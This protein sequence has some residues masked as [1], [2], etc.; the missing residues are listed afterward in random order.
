M[1]AGKIAGANPF[2]SN[3]THGV[4][5]SS[6]PKDLETALQLLYL[7]FTDPRFDENEFQ[8]GIQQIMAVLPNLSKDPDFIFK[9]KIDQVFYNNNPRVTELTEETVKK[10]NLATIERVYRQLFKD[11]AGAEVIIVGNVDLETLKPLVEKYIG[12]LPKGKKATTWTVDNCISVATG[13]IEETVKLPMQT[14]KSTVRQLYTAYL[15]VDIKTNVTL[16]AANYILDMIYTKTIREDQGG[17]YG[18]GSALQG[19]REPS[20]RIDVHVLFS[21]NPEAAE[22][23]TQ[24]A[25][26]ELKKYAENGP[27][28]EQFNKA[29]ENLKKNL[30]EKR[31]NNGYWMNALSH[32]AEYGEDYDA[33]YEAAI[34]SLTAKDIQTVLQAILAQ[35]NFIEV[36]LTPAE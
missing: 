33:L 2:I 17:T 32:Y 4:S 7:T 8:T 10:A 1:L 12:S 16:D 15:P 9:Q 35:G 24:I 30:P 6:T 25:I 34:N 36:T 11:V 26:D 14:P 19:R 18:V 28:E 29:M 13:V 31:I 5:A 3:L 23:L 27:T 22:K 21:T 20:G